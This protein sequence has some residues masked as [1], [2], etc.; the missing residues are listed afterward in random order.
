MNKYLCNRDNNSST[1]LLLIPWTMQTFMGN[2]VATSF[3]EWA[4]KYKSWHASHSHTKCSSLS[5]CF[6]FVSF[7]Y[8]C[9]FIALPSNVPGILLG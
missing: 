9:S 4:P 3:E 6:E 8:F 7:A 2:M 5:S 1:H